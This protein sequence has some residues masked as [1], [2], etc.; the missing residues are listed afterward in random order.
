[1]P[2]ELT[3]LEP[4]IGLVLVNRPQVRNALNWEA[5][6]TFASKIEELHA[7]P[8]LRAVILSGA[9]KAFIAGG[10]LKQLHQH[11]TEADGLR[12]SRLMTDALARLEALPCVSIAAV[13]GPARGGGA[14]IA[15]ACDLRVLDARADIGFVQI[16]LGLTPGWGAGQRLLRLAGYSRALE[17]LAG[18]RILSPEEAVACG[19]ANRIAP[20]GETLQTALALSR[21]IARYDP[22]VVRAL[23][24]LL[25]AGLEMAPGQAAAAEQAEFPPLWAAEAHLQAVARFLDRKGD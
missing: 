19:L 7:H 10:D 16:R 6:E 3:M 14:E 22:D 17:I 8:D 11:P 12:L 9:G 20:E 4:G 13:N 1:M 21:E 23:K 5:M 25:R 24:R 18:G 15:L 2:I